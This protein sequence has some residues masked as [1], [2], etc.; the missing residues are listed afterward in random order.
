MADESQQTIG[1]KVSSSLASM[2][3]LAGANVTDAVIL[4]SL[5]D[6]SSSTASPESASRAARLPWAFINKEDCLRYYADFIIPYTGE[7]PFFSRY[8]VLFLLPVSPWAKPFLL[9]PC[10]LLGTSV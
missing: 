4:G 1:D 9:L 3:G 5:E 6:H 7:F 2:F 10:S 8:M